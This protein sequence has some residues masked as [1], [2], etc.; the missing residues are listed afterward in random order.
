MK[1]DDEISTLEASFHSIVLPYRRCMGEAHL[2]LTPTA[3]VQARFARRRY[4]L[5]SRM[6]VSIPKS[7]LPLGLTTI[8]HCPSKV[9]MA[10]IEISC[11]WPP[12]S[13]ILT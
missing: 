2:N 12:A 8:E 1:H 4:L 13:L 3:M 9:M 10:H 6:R 11:E 7:P 5:D